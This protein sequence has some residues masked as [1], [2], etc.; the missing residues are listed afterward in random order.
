M[1]PRIR[2]EPMNTALRVCL[3]GLVVL[4]KYDREGG[5]FLLEGQAMFICS[6]TLTG[7]KIT[8]TL[9]T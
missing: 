6:V 1:I 7:R 5:L 8:S 9:E 4:M 2:M 3:L